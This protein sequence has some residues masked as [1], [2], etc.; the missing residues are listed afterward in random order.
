MGIYFGC[1]M[2][3]FNRQS[4]TSRP[5]SS[6]GFIERDPAE[7][8]NSLADDIKITHPNVAAVYRNLADG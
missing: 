4:F 2:Q 8:F 3:V 7:R 6:G 1:R 5:A